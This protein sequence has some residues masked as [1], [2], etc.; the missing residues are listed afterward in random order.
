MFSV[1]VKYVKK[2]TRKISK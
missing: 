2:V 1:C